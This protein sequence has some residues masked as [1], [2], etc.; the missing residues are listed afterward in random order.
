MDTSKKNI[1][2]ARPLKLA[3]G[4]V[5][6][7]IAV[8]VLAHIAANRQQAKED[9]RLDR[10]QEQQVIEA[11]PERPVRVPLDMPQMSWKTYW[12]LMLFSNYG[13]FPIL[14]V[15]GHLFIA[16]YVAWMI[17]RHREMAPLYE[18]S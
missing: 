13:L 10:G 2:A 18:L 16:A 4:V 7:S 1:R 11:E 17:K 6:V 9:L 15:V 3:A 14:V 5:G 8:G 12:S